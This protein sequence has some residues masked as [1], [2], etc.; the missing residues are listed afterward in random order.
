MRVGRLQLLLILFTSLILAACG[1]V[2]YDARIV[3]AMPP[4]QDSQDQ[5]CLHRAD[6]KEVSLV[7]VS[8]ISCS[9]ARRDYLLLR[10]H[11]PYFRAY[12]NTS[13]GEDSYYLHYLVRNSWIQEP[14]QITI[15][16]S[17]GPLRMDPVRSDKKCI[18]GCAYY[19]TGLGQR[20]DE[21]QQVYR[22]PAD[23]VEGLLDGSLTVEDDQ[24][25][26]SFSKRFGDVDSMAL[27]IREL[28]RIHGYI[29]GLKQNDL[30]AL[31]V[32]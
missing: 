15:A 8:V 18:G 22:M 5:R 26:A 17:D 9:L 20:R 3:E 11:R 19:G 28:E 4:V 12:L 7:E 2:P 31:A 23:I 16:T 29:Q 24:L 25:V 21:A 30:G 10:T 14:E 32:R 27:N 1:G 13:T 6:L